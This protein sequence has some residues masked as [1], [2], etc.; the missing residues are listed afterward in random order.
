[1]HLSRSRS[2][3]QKLSLSVAFS[4]LTSPCAMQAQ[5]G[6]TTDW[7]SYAGDAQRTGWEKTD[8]K[9]TKSDVPD[10]RLLWNMKI[11]SNATGP[12]TV[13]APLV[14]GNLIGSRGFKELAFVASSS[15]HLTSIDA[16]LAR[17]Y[18][19]KDVE[20]AP[21]KAAKGG[22][23]CMARMTA[24][25]TLAAP[26][27]F[28]FGA[29]APS[30]PA[31]PSGTAAASTN[32][33]RDATT[34]QSPGGTPR[35]GG[36]NAGPASG[37]GAPAPRS[38]GVPGP[39]I[40]PG[41]ARLF[42]PKPIYVLTSGGTLHKFNVDNGAEMQPPIPFL[43]PNANA[44]S[45]NIA[46][47][48]V[49]TT[50]TLNCGGVPNAVWAID[51]SKPSPNQA[52]SFS[53]NGDDF[54]GIGGPVL[55]TDGTVYVQ[56]G[57][58]E[59]DPA[60]NK[61]GSAVLALTAKEL[62]LK[63]YFAIPRTQSTRR[64][65]ELNGTS[66]LVFAHKGKDLVVTAGKDGRIYLLDSASLGGADN[67]TPLFRT[68]P[69]AKTEPAVDAGGVWG[70]LSTWAEA[71]G[72]RYVL[73]PVW[74]QLNPELKAPNDNGDVKNGAIV[75]FK[76]DDTG[77]KP[78][79]TLAW[80]SRNMSSPAPP[81][82]AQ[83]VV[84]ALSNGESGRKAKK[85]GNDHATLYGLDALTGKEIY[86][87]ADQVKVPGALTGVSIANGRVYFATADNTIW[88]FGK[89]LETGR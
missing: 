77:D 38:Q 19:E 84:F 43:P 58:A 20:P 12:R 80:V 1:M 17:M 63:S 53:L 41:M 35:P 64:S 32:P 14:L 86:S 65:P 59:L 16:D 45:L 10:F 9:F 40:P 62:K 11:A 88:A 39:A 78:A 15:G 8:Q 51:F 72:T 69:V 49:Y 2:S 83:G 31:P 18:W 89:Y 36:A 76:L 54:V 23:A 85:S 79:L 48:V 33:V 42:Q 28:R 47:S 81:V 30:T 73:A 29:P 50:T 44:H 5:L 60:A 34:T 3:R 24:M 7:W 55:G 68:E 13:M 56:T 4:L 71:N 37:P 67:A 57:D 22:S 27:V 74:G 70:G 25:P 75:A 87:T 26:F 21:G 6:Q 46:E 82:I 66:P 52:V 61:Y